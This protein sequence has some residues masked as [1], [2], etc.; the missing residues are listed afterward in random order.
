MALLLDQTDLCVK[1]VTETFLNAEKETI[2]YPN[3]VAIIIDIVLRYL[4]D[5]LFHV[6]TLIASDGVFEFALLAERSYT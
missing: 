3:D 4:E 5:A 1:F 2:F 6:E